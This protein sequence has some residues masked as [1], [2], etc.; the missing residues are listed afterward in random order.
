MKGDGV[1]KGVST[2]PPPGPRG[3]QPT[4]PPLDPKADPL[5]PESDTP[6]WTQRQT[7]GPRGRTPPPPVE[8][9]TEAGGTHPTGMHSC[10]IINSP[11][12]DCRSTG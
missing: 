7:P 6:P 10:I 8:M 4:P 12:I 2:T 9:A 1:V 3:R 11:I 5:D